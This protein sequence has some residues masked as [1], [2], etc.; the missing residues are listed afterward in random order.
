MLNAGEDTANIYVFAGVM[1]A[2]T[3]VIFAVTGNNIIIKKVP[4]EIVSETTH[5]TLALAATQARSSLV[6]PIAV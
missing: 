4:E 5:A 3:P 1:P 6:N 2:L